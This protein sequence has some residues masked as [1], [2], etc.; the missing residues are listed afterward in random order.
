MED[1]DALHK[2]KGTTPQEHEGYFRE[3]NGS[4]TVTDEYGSPVARICFR[5]KAKRGEAWNA[6]DPEG[7][8]NAGFIVKAVNN[9]AKLLEACEYAL[10]F[11]LL[12]AEPVAKGDP[13]MRIAADRVYPT[14]E[15]LQAAIAEAEGS[16]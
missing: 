3:N 11:A 9:H 7:Q 8:A 15:T 16:R 1:Y 5:G 13:Y 12:S 2:L 14:I 4:W 6:P 10:R